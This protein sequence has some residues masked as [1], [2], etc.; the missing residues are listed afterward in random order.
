MSLGQ[1]IVSIVFIALAVLLFVLAIRH[2]AGTPAR[3]A[4]LRTAAI[5]AAIGTLMSLWRP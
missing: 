4:R 1:R 5:F 2:P 3:K